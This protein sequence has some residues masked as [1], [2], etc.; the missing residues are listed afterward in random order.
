MVASSFTPRTWHLSQF[1]AWGQG[2]LPEA[3]KRNVY[4]TRLQIPRV[5]ATIKSFMGL[6]VLAFCL[7]PHNQMVRRRNSV[8]V[9]SAGLRNTTRTITGNR[10]GSSLPSGD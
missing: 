2:R 9:Q 7:E 6:S 10:F 8:T 5:G 3:N 1:S 4:E